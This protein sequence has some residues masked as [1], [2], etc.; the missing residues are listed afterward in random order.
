MAAAEKH[1][2]LLNYKANILAVDIKQINLI[3]ASDE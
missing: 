1:I 3:K 2:S